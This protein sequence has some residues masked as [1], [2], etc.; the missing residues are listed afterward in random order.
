MQK[1]FKPLVSIILPTF[2][3]A[4]FLPDAFEAIKE[5][6]FSDWELIIVDDGSKDNTKEIVDKFKREISQKVIYLYQEN[7]GPAAARNKGLEYAR[8]KYIAFCDSDDIWLSHHLEKCVDAL[9]K[10]S[11]IDW[12]FGACRLVEYPSGKIINPNHFYNLD[13]NPRKILKLKTISRNGLF[14]FTDQESV[15]K[16]AL[17]GEFSAGPQHSLIRHKLFADHKF[18]ERFRIGEDQ[19]LVLR[20][21]KEG[22]RFSFFKEVH[23]IYRIHNYNISLAARQN[24]VEEKVQKTLE[25]VNAL[26]ETKNILSFSEKMV[27]CRRIANVY[28][29]NIGYLYFQNKNYS[30]AL[31]FFLRGIFLNPLSLKFWKTTLWFL[32]RFSLFRL[33]FVK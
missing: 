28:F 8:G 16:S 33:G 15:I 27:L 32:L 13:G 31:H 3:R 17:S 5:Q 14:V 2:N 26:R 19:L 24:T 18:D 21:L 25:F 30:E 20:S 6:S 29:W 1:S 22:Y 4:H 11:D 7:K 10:N 9:E 12:V 23:V